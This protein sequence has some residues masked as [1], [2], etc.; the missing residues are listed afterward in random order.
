MFVDKRF[1]VWRIPYKL[2][3]I[4]G[5]VSEVAG[6]TQVVGVEEEPVALVVFLAGSQVE[7]VHAIHVVEVTTAH[8]AG[9]A[10][11]AG[12]VVLGEALVVDDEVRRSCPA[13][14]SAGPHQSVWGITTLIAY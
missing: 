11:C 6:A 2:A 13:V 14:R 5:R 1:A 4:T 7:A 3:A 12:I 9:Y 8:L 10:L